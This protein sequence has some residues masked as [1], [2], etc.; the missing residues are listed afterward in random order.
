MEVVNNE[1]I[2][3]ACTWDSPAC[4]HSPE[5]LIGLIEEVGFLPLFSNSIPGFS[6]EEHTWEN[7]LVL[8]VFAEKPMTLAQISYTKSLAVSSITLATP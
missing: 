3:K 7:T 8:T 6:A 5:E 2:M 4:L 1:W